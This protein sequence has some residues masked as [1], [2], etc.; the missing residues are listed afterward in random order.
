MNVDALSVVAD[1]WRLRWE[2]AMER[3]ARESV[4]DGNCK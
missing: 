3:R 2:Q 4:P 1:N